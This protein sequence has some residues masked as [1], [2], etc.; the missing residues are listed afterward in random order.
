MSF[1]FVTLFVVF[2]KKVKRAMLMH[3]FEG[4]VAVNKMY[5]YVAGNFFITVGALIGF[6][7]VT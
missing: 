1:V 4:E 3:F 5:C 2:L 7:E 6:F